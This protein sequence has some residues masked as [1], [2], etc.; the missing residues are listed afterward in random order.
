MSV[1]V[2][3]P[4]IACLPQQQRPFSIAVPAPSCHLSTTTA[5]HTHKHTLPRCSAPLPQIFRAAVCDVSVNTMTLEVTGKEEKML[6]LKEVLEPYG[7]RARTRM[8]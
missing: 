7:E 4:T 3:G 1:V 8:A 2:P 5:V 6:A